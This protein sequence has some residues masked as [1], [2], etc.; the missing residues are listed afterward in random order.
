MSSNNDE[1]NDSM[2]SE[3]AKRRGRPP[4]VNKPESNGDGAPK[5]GR[6]GPPK[7]GGGAPG[8]ASGGV[9]K[10]RGRPSKGSGSP[11]GSPKKLRSPPK[12]AAAAPPAGGSSSE[13]SE[14]A[15]SDDGGNEEAYSSSGS[16]KKTSSS[17]A[18]K[19]KSTRG[20]GRPAGNGP[21]KPKVPYVP[22]GRPRGRPP[23]KKVE[24]RGAH[25]KK[26]SDYRNVQA[27]TNAGESNGN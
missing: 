16:P 27:A 22:N 11:S 19:P 18:Y 17:A 15:T 13:E 5:K 3:T 10:G 6:G 26:G 4:G 1:A 8:V 2:S 14:D 23:G 7:A 12:R 25:L 9:K 21:K 20:R 24:N